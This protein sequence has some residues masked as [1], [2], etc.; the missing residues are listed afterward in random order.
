MSNCTIVMHLNSTPS[1]TDQFLSA[2]VAQTSLF[3]YYKIPAKYQAL[4]AQWY[5]ASSTVDRIHKFLL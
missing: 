1:K 2:L 3:V 5:V 4:V